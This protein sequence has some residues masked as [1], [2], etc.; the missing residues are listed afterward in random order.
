MQFTQ[1]E[2]DELISQPG[3]P[4]L[5]GSDLSGAKLSGRHLTGADLSGANLRNAYLPKFRPNKR[6]HATAG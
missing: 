4:Q 2:L 5:S 6:P 3:S 1:P